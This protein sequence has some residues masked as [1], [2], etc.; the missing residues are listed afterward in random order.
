MGCHFVEDLVAA[1][2]AVTV[3]GRSRS[4]FRPLPAEVQYVS[5]ELADSKL[6]RKVLQ[7][8]DAVAHLVSGTVPS[9]GD[10][11]PGRDVEINLLGT[12][13]LLE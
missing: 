11:D 12:L 3:M 9:T 8:I 5:G 1:G 13:S 10:K 4:S 6:M 2:H 7:D